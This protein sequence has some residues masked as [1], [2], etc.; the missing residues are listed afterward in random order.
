MTALGEALQRL[1]LALVEEADVQPGQSLAYGRPHQHPRARYF[2]RYAPSGQRVAGVTRIG[3]DCPRPR[4]GRCEC[5]PDGSWRPSV[6]VTRA[7]ARAQHAVAVPASRLRAELAGQPLWVDEV[8]EQSKADGLWRCRWPVRRA[9]EH[10]RGVSPR[11]WAIAIGLLR[12]DPLASVWGSHG[13]PPDPMGEALRL[14]RQLERWADEERLTAWE[15]RPRQW[16]DEPRQPNARSIRKSEA[17]STAEHEARD[18]RQVQP[19]DDAATLPRETEAAKRPRSVSGPGPRP[20]QPSG[21]SG[22]RPLSGMSSPSD[23]EEQACA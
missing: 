22:A 13:A 4:R 1:R 20:E 6:G 9:L 17:Q 19:V 5:P 23:R 7:D 15:H 21:Q 12:G 18:E 16:W 2:P 8:Y 14:I 11:R 10:L 3:P